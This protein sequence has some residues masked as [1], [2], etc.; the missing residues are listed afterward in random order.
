MRN[1]ID[2]YPKVPIG[3]T[4]AGHIWTGVTWEPEPTF[5]LPSTKSTLVLAAIALLATGVTAA[6]VNAFNQHSLP[7]HTISA[8]AGGDPPPDFRSDI[9]KAETH[10]SAEREEEYILNG[11]QYGGYP[12]DQRKFIEVI[13][14]Y[15]E[16][17]TDA[18]SDAQAEAVLIRERDEE[19]VEIIGEKLKVKNWVGTVMDKGITAEGN[20]YI[21]VEIA[22]DLRLVTWSTAFSDL[23]SATLIKPGSKMFAEFENVHIGQNVIISGHFLPG[24]DTDLDQGNW[25]EKNYGIKPEFL[26]HFEHLHAPSQPPRGM[27]AD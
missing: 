26:F 17:I 7:E 9:T 10:E 3:E 4:V 13:M 12:D 22:Q 27:R 20:G 23:T 21:M 5:R 25:T 2:Y 8:P 6:V 11:T 14:V 24:E 16:Q 19:L 1:A 18:S 15:R